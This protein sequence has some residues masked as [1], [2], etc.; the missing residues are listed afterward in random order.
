MSARRRTKHTQRAGR[1]S[2]ESTS[3]RPSTDPVPV[4][5]AAPHISPEEAV[6]TIHEPK[7]EADEQC[8]LMPVWPWGGHRNWA[9]D[10]VRFMR[11]P[12]IAELGV[13]WGTSLFAFAQAVKDGS[14]ASRLIGV[15]TWRGDNH[16][17]PYGTEVLGT[18]REIA[19]RYYPRQQFD[20]HPMTFDEALPSVEDASID[21]LHIDGF[22][23]YE[24]V[25]HDFNTWLP[26]LAPEGVILL[27][28]VDESTGYGSARYWKD[29]LRRHPG[30]A[31]THSWGLGVVFPKGDRWLR[32]LGRNGL[33][34]KIALYTYKA[35]Y[36]RSQI[37]LTDTGK[38]AVE[39]L[40]VI[41]H[42]GTM[43]RDRDTEIASLKGWLGER[44]SLIQTRDQELAHIRGE[45]DSVRSSLASIQ[46]L[47]QTLRSRVSE[48]EPLAEKVPG[49]EASIRDL[50]GRLDESTSL[51][52]TLRSQ[53]ELAQVR[54]GELESSLSRAT[55]D[56]GEAREN[57]AALDS[58]VAVLDQ[59]IEIL[60]ARL[61]ESEHVQVAMSADMQAMFVRIDSQSREADELRSLLAR[62]HSMNEATRDQLQQL[63]ADVEML[64]LRVEQLERLEIERERAA[65]EGAARRSAPNGRKIAR[66]RK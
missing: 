26:K 56:L 23:E 1:T 28:D 34:D 38:M 45:A 66:E 18:V 16:T 9:Y 51:L 41:D 33:R 20:F 59:T 42:M 32:A 62:S 58:R 52:A 3:S 25:E 5:E 44:D 43:I 15:D 11:P 8:P 14:L 30:F 57:I 53:L 54:A 7:F 55:A 37:E 10:L 60:R 6:W 47:A 27:H 61:R 2:R 35:R 12:V 36:E 31:F 17:G 29:L 13:H 46:A 39:R 50:V 19:E 49:L 22:H 63:A 65:G 64:A 21:L 24:A 40:H 48:L 4:V